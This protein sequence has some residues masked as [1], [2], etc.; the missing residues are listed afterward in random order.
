VYFVAD[1]ASIGSEDFLPGSALVVC[2]GVSQGLTDI[3]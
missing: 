1:G 3:E 2:P